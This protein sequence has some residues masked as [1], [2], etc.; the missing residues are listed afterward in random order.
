MQRWHWI[1]ALERRFFSD[2]YSNSIDKRRRASIRVFCFSYPPSHQNGVFPKSHSMPHFNSLHPRAYTDVITHCQ[3]SKDS[4]FEFEFDVWVCQPNSTLIS[5]YR[6]NHSCCVLPTFF[7]FSFCT[8]T[9]LLGRCGMV[10]LHRVIELSTPT[11][12]GNSIEN[13]GSKKTRPRIACTP[14]PGGIKNEEKCKLYTRSGFLSL[15]FRTS[16]LFIGNSFFPL[17]FAIT[18]GDVVCIWIVRPW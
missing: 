3:Q 15:I 7:L 18:D 12:S 4:S 14:W 2:T 10:R 9:T 6:L 13:K 8:C 17:L 16:L 11:M 1:S 5:I